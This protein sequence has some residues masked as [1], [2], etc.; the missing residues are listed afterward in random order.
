MAN[1]NSSHKNI[2]SR[3]FNHS[4]RSISEGSQ[5][6]SSKS[7][8]R[9]LLSKFTTTSPSQSTLLTFSTENPCGG[10]SLGKYRIFSWYILN[11]SPIVDSSTVTALDGMSPDCSPVMVDSSQYP[12]YRTPPASAG[13]HALATSP[14]LQS[15][16]P[17]DSAPL[18]RPI[19][20]HRSG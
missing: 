10:T 15:E 19:V 3:L 5:G 12:D 18:V 16:R 9:K 20:V 11:C 14:A 2:L 7:R 13:P 6:H 1:N 17:Y 4:Q 8:G